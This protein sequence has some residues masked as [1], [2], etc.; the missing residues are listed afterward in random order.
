M[1]G[2]IFGKLSTARS[3]HQSFTAHGANPTN[4]ETR[5]LDMNNEIGLSA[6]LEK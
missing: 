4:L 6:A 3:D 1:D 5:S 2:V